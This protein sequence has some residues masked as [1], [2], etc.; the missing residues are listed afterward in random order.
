MCSVSRS[1]F[2]L[3]NLGVKREEPQVHVACNYVSRSLL[4]F[5]GLFFRALLAVSHIHRRSLLSVKALLQDF[6]GSG[7]LWQSS[8]MSVCW[9]G[10]EAW[11]LPSGH[12]SGTR[13]LEEV[14]R[15]S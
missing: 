13:F 9:R 2:A 8:H 1:L 11:I 12:T 15:L 14:C 10:K 3:A 5:I 7:L 6:F 4:S